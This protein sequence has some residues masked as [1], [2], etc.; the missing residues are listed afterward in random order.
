MSALPAALPVN[1]QLID[2]MILFF[3]AAGMKM[4]AALR[5]SVVGF[6]VDAIQ[7]QS[8]TGWSVLAVGHASEVADMKVI[9]TARQTGLR[10]WASGDRSRLISIVP[11]V[12]TGRRLS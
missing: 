5:N 8:E 12:V 11:E 4:C 10:P 3:T 9:A 6:E 1:Y 7:E 2:G